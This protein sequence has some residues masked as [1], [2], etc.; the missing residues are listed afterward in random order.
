MLWRYIQG[1]LTLG[2]VITVPY[3]WLKLWAKDFAA[4]LED[5]NDCGWEPAD[6]EMVIWYSQMPKQQ[7][8][9]VR[10]AGILSNFRAPV[11]YT[12][13]TLPTILRV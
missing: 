11:S 13:L 7:E 5:C 12:H 4:M 2:H 9:Y 8:Y 3:A 1:R 10:A 6:I